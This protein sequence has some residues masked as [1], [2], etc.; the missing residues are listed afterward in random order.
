MLEHLIF[1]IQ[2]ATCRVVQNLKG[3]IFSLKNAAIPVRGPFTWKSTAGYSFEHFVGVCAAHPE[4][5]EVACK[6]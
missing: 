3:V 1:P 4:R 5:L 6:A 2:T